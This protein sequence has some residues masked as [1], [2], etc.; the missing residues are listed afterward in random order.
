VRSE[1]CSKQLW[2][3]GS[4]GTKGGKNSVGKKLYFR[5]KNELARGRKLG[6]FKRKRIR[7]REKAGKGKWRKKKVSS[8][9]G[10][11]KNGD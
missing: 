7:G 8:L 5:E 4:L 11:Q 6:K 1:G 9:H 10:L 2:G 3:E